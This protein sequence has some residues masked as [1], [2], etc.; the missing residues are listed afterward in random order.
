MQRKK[1]PNFIK[2]HLLYG[3]ARVS[4][5]L[6]MEGVATPCRN[7]LRWESF[8]IYCTS[9]NVCICPNT[10]TKIVIVDPAS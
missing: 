5:T 6:S 10:F 1:S 7:S 8:G 4:K 3:I 9:A 2:G